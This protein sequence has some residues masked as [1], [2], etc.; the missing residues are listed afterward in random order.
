[1]V[2]DAGRD[3]MGLKAL[4]DSGALVRMLQST[5][6]PDSNAYTKMQK[7]CNRHGAAGVPCWRR[8]LRGN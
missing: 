3:Y 6:N 8:S 1:M 7:V 5:A 2:L 4:E